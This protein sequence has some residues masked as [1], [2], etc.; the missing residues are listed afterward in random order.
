VPQRVA[1]YKGHKAVEKNWLT[2]YATVD[3]DAWFPPSRR[4]RLAANTTHVPG[5]RTRMF[6]TQSMGPRNG[7]VKD[8][9]WGLRWEMD[10]RLDWTG[11][12]IVPP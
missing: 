4:E 5:H 6:G 10:P 9:Q 2:E 1:R 8:D 7:Y 11:L 12:W 3:R